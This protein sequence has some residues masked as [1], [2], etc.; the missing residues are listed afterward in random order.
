MFDQ[1]GV[2]YHVIFP[3]EISDI[4]PLLTTDGVLGAAYSP[5]D[6]HL[7]AS[8]ATFAVAKAAKMKG[9]AIRTQCKAETVKVFLK[10]GEL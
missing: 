3:S 2:N 5:D 9:A 6:G 8:G 10:S 7:D 1:L 4:H